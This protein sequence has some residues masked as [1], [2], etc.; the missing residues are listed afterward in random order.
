MNK[1]YKPLIEAHRGASGYEVDNTIKAFDKAIELNSDTIEL[2][3]RKTKDN[4]IIVFHDPTF[5]GKLIIDYTYDELLSSSLESGFKVP[6]LTDVLIKY[7]SK[8]LL[9]IEIKEE[10]YEEE[11][12]NLILSILDINEF[13]IRSFSESTINKVKSI[14]KDIYSILLIGAEFPK[15]GI[16]SR[17][18]E[19]FP[20]GKIIQNF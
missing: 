3:I 4:H 15:Y 10:G 18:G 12:I 13:Y 19:I 9:D 6:L 11:I 17:F 5:K 20:K 16:F 2:D 7:K 1:A 8:I 14:N